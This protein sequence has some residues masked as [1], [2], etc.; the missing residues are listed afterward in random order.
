MSVHIG[1]SGWS[2]AHWANVLYP[3]DLPTEGR[4]EARAMRGGPR[5]MIRD[6]TEGAL[7]GMVKSDNHL[8][9]AESRDRL[10]DRTKMRVHPWT[11]GRALRRLGLT[12]KKEDLTCDRAGRGRDLGGTPSLA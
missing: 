10:A 7:K 2:Y 11:V 6:E 12:R 8:T 4:L 9:L 1:T 5:P 3:E